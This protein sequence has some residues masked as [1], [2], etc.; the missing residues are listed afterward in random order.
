[1][2]VMTSAV[3]SRIATDFGSDLLMAPSRWFAADPNPQL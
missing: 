3:E 2:D 1:V